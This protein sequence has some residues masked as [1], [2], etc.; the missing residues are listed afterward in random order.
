[1]IALDTRWEIR[2]IMQDLDNQSVV[3]RNVTEA[4]REARKLIKK[5]I[6]KN[7]LE[8]LKIR[9]VGTAKIEGIAKQIEGENKRNVETVRFII[10]RQ[11]NNVKQKIKTLRKKSQEKTCRAVKS[12]E[13]GWRR[14]KILEILKV[15]KQ[16][17][18][19]NT[20]NK[21][22]KTVE[23][24]ERKY[25][26]NN[27]NNNTN[28][29]CTEVE[30]IGIGDDDLAKIGEEER[31]CEEQRPIAIGC[32]IDDDE[33]EFLKMPKNTTDFPVFNLERTLT[34]IAAM[35]CK[36]KMTFRDDEEIPEDTTEGRKERMENIKE[37]VIAN[38]VVNEEEKTVNFA[39]KRVTEL[40]T[41]RRITVPKSLKSTRLET[42]IINL[43]SNLEEEVKKEHK[44]RQQQK[45][46]ETILSK[47]QMCGKKKLLARVKKKE[48]VLAESDKS[49]KVT[50]VKTENFLEMIAPHVEND[51]IVNMEDVEE[52]E[53][54]M[55]A[56]SM[57]I[58]RVLR[59]GESN[60]QEARVASA[61]K[62]ASS[63]I[64]PLDA[65]IKDHKKVQNIPVR[66]VCKSKESPNGI[67][68][69]LIGDF[70]E[71]HVCTN[72]KDKSDECTSTEEM[73]AKIKE[74]NDRFE[75]EEEGLEQE[76]IEQLP[77]PVIGSYDII[78]MYPE[79][80]MKKCAETARRM[81]E[82]SEM[83]TNVNSEQLGLFIASTMTQEQINAEGIQDIVHSRRY[84]MGGRPG[85]V[86]KSVT[87]SDTEREE[88]TSWKPPNRK[89]TQQEI[90]KLLGI[91][92]ETAI[93]VI[94]N[95]HYYILG[96]T[97][98][99]QTKGGAIGLRM[100][101]I[102]AK[103]FM[104][105]FDKIFKHKLYEACILVYLYSRYIDDINSV[106]N[107]LPSGSRY[108]DGQ[109]QQTE[110]DIKYDTE[111]NVQSD[112]IT[113]EA[114]KLIGNSI[115][116]EIKLT[117]DY[118]SNYE[119]G[120]IPILDLQCKVENRRL[121]HKFYEKTVNTP[122]TILQQSAHSARIKRST[123]IQETVRR[124]VNT[125]KFVSK[126]EK[127][128]IMQRY[129]RKLQ[130]SGYPLAYRRSII[131]AAYSIYKDKITADDNGSRPLYRNK[132]WNKENRKLK[133][134]IEPKTWYSDENKTHH[135]PLILDPTKGG[136]LAKKLD[137][138]CKRETKISGLR[139]K[140]VERGG[141]RLSSVCGS[142]PTKTPGCKR[143]NCIICNGENPGQCAE[144]GPIY[145]VQCIQCD[146]AGS[147]S[148]YI[149]ES[150]KSGFLRSLD[151]IKAIRTL[152]PKNALGKHCIVQHGGQHIDI[153]MR[154][155]AVH[156]KCIM[157]QNGEAVWITNTECDLLMN[158]RIEHHQP[159]I[160]R[161]LIMNGNRQEDQD[162]HQTYMHT[163][164]ENI[165]QTTD[166]QEQ[167]TRAR[168]AR[169]GRPRGGGRGIGRQQTV[170]QTEQVREQT[171]TQTRGRPRGRPRG[172]RGTRARPAI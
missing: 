126:T 141:Q 71:A 152:D 171:Q 42:K 69:D 66:G 165:T 121:A 101:G 76:Q 87:G 156:K 143:E 150:G 50:A 111:N 136:T 79:L 48:I 104:E 65:M 127:V 6:A 100:T 134:E 27:N 137:E 16:R 59:L 14:W 12:V 164:R 60:G 62:S 124:L 103:L 72:I 161:I 167:P 13:A 92:V 146:E 97:I 110:E 86:A 123:L 114:I 93:M 163:E 119:T 45:I 144:L 4:L 51:E 120:Y 140:V 19:R 94:M 15:E 54:E 61:M 147:K 70:L 73:C 113:F 43:T 117:V 148:I 99:R 38:R 18:W 91:M 57:I 1:M 168:G 3:E 37:E 98:R 78:A 56:M 31:E 28:D 160:S 7:K 95:N 88:A 90:K 118:C 145:A 166:T 36:L 169:R 172:S 107:R 9:G 155:L 135:A 106:F 132:Q 10:D 157:R 125:N 85:I 128:N 11:L 67:L 53:K 138:I 130:I 35:T 74:V 82:N 17:T 58:A 20:K 133:K 149:G 39:K 41:C 84:T 44:K 47:Q 77:K 122:Y 5:T 154:I 115:C 139:I 112:K 102:L 89:P 80:D 32:T 142:N 81:T 33:A 49:G 162:R 109:I 26:D 129:A 23:H 22:M 158:S 55:S 108:V 131:S 64:P 24:L 63:K 2:M 105:E 170:D 116:P 52:A 8:K 159:P 29:K 68:N 40:K 25:K 30:G 96:D 21:M 151:H 34:D 153:K 75:Q 83:T 46:V